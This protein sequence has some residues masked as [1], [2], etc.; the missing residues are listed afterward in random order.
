MADVDERKCH[1]CDS[2]EAE[3]GETV[4]PSDVWLK[5]SPLIVEH[6]LYWNQGRNGRCQEC[7]CRVDLTKKKAYV[8]RK[9]EELSFELKLK[10]V[11]IDNAYAYAYAHDGAKEA[12]IPTDFSLALCHP[13]I[14]IINWTNIINVDRW[15]WPRYRVC[16]CGVVGSYCSGHHGRHGQDLLVVSGL[17]VH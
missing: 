11:E 3:G 6:S 17:R 9:L 1:L 8:A 16:G 12:Y 10:E 4:L 15:F 5:A 14:G 13:C 7:C 2:S